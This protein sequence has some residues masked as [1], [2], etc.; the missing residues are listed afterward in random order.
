[1]SRNPNPYRVDA[2][3]SNSID[4]K[5]EQERRHML[6]AAFKNSDELAARLV[7]RLLDKHIIE[8]NS[9]SS[10]REVFVKILRGLQ[11]LDE[12]EFNFK[13]APVRGLIPNANLISLYLAQYIIEDL[14]NHRDIEDIFGDESEIYQVV[15]SIMNSLLLQ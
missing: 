14:I 1:M 13:I 9:E 4:R 7:Q 6:H 8:T 3:T 15:D 2:Q 12:H 10:I 5:R 11:D